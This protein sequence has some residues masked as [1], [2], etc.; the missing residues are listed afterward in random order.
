MQYRG[1]CNRKSIV[2]LT[3]SFALKIPSTALH[4]KSTLVTVLTIRC[5]PQPVLHT[6]YLLYLLEKTYFSPPGTLITS[7]PSS[8]TNQNLGLTTDAI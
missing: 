3:P 1:V 5:V 2:A 8:L 4:L 7:Q 6:D